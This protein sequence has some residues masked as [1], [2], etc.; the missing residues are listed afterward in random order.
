MKKDVNVFFVESPLQLFSATQARDELEINNAMLFVNV[1]KSK[2][3]HNDQLLEGIDDKWESVRYLERKSSL[4]GYLS[5]MSFLIYLVVILRGKVQRFFYGEFRN[6]DYA[7]YEGLLEPKESILLDDGT[8]TIVVQK[9]YIMNK[10]CIFKFKSLKEKIFKSLLLRER[11]PKLYTFF[12]LDCY[13]LPCQ[14]NYF[15]KNIIARAVKTNSDFAFMGSK[16]S[17]IGFLKEDDELK[18]LN[19]IYNES[20]NGDFIYYPHRG[21]S[22]EK[23]RKISLIGYKIES[24]NS[25]VEK[26]YKS[27]QIMPSRV[28]SYYSTTL[29]TCLLSFGESVEI[30]ALDIRSKLSDKADIESINTIYEYYM[31]FGIKLI[32]CNNKSGE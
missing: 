11:V 12:D 25:P 31:D 15:N 30:C 3:K 8:V 32:D 10:L 24:L 21:E 16:L 13:M 1:N 4:I 6:S 14:I 26:F 19:E 20:P 17:E 2:K 29:Y 23:I 22:T 9:K 18:I 5:F 28:Y 27:T 7:I